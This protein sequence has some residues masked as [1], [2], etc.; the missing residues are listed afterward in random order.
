MKVLFIAN[1]FPSPDLPNKGAFN[2]R[3]AKQIRALADNLQ[4]LHLRAWRPGR[5]VWQSYNMDGI[6]VWAFSFPFYD[7]LGDTITGLVT[8][9]Y[10]NALFFSYLKERIKAFDVIHSVG[11]GFSGI[12]GAFVSEKTGKPHIAQCIG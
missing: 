4:V 11:L 10:K 6:P 5:P 7:L 8:G 1:A 9:V 2:Y 3:G 12:V